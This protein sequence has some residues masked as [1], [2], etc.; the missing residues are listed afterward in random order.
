MRTEPGNII[1]LIIHEGKNPNDQVD[2]SMDHPLLNNFKTDLNLTLAEAMRMATTRNSVTV[3]AK[4]VFETID[5]SHD[6]HIQKEIQPAEYKIKVGAKTE[7]FDIKGL[8]KGFSAVILGERIV[9]VD[10]D[11]Q[12]G[13]DEMQ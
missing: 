4:I 13:L 5:T 6:E 12:I 8:T 1:N 9:L 7:G 2:I 10:P 3:T 11:R